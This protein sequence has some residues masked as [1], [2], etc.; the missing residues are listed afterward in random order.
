MSDTSSYEDGKTMEQVAR[1]W[2]DSLV[3]GAET[4]DLNYESGYG[5]ETF[6]TVRVILAGG[7]PACYVEFTF[8][9][10]EFPWEEQPLSGSLTY[11]EPWKPSVTVDFADEDA[12]AVWR[13]L[14]SL[15][16]EGDD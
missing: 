4:G 6:T 8:E 9:L 13:A 12:D 11:M 3:S 16:D 5:S 10:T 7:G 2:R 1:N 14:N 15:P